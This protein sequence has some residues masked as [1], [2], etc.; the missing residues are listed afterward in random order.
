VSLVAGRGGGDER[1][2]LGATVS[3]GSEYWAPF[4]G[5]DQ[6]N[7]PAF[8]KNSLSKIR[9][10]LVDNG[11]TAAST[12]ARCKRCSGLERRTGQCVKLSVCPPWISA[13]ECSRGPDRRIHQVVKLNNLTMT[14]YMWGVGP[15][16]SCVSDVTHRSVTCNNVE[17]S[18]VVADM[19]CAAGSKPA[20][21]IASPCSGG[22]LRDGGCG[23]C[24]YK[25][26]VGRICYM[27]P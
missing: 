15:W 14:Q 7:L 6:G 22:P 4:C 11:C 23:F 9:V 20:E 13:E 8:C 12:D 1:L 25:I 5:E 16:G 17:T 21:S 19:N 2:R 27:C 18:E 10:G 24:S 26:G 3:P